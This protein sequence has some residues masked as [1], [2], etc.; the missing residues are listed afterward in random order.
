MRT[1]YFIRDSVTKTYYWNACNS[2]GHPFADAV[3]HTTETSVKSGVKTRNTMFRKDLKIPDE[4]CS[5]RYAWLKKNR[6]AARKREN[7][8]DF[9]ME[10]IAVEIQDPA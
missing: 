8:P 4:D 1:L 10:I 3:I 6:G 9:G 2:F 7:L 5:G